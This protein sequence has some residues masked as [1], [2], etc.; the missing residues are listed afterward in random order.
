MSIS[1][2]AILGIGKVFR[3]HHEATEWLLN[4]CPEVSREK[5]DKY[6]L[7]ECLDRYPYLAAVSAT[8]LNCYTGDGFAIYIPLVTRDVDEFIALQV[9]AIREWK[10]IFSDEPEFVSEVVVS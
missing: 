9:E 4:K 3:D 10:E 6:G 5:I 1:Y 2:D 7:E 8:T